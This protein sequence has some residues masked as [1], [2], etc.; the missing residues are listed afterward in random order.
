[1]SG[2]LWVNMTTPGVVCCSVLLDERDERAGVKLKDAD[3]I[4]IPLQII[5]GEKKIGE[6]NLELKT[7]KTGKIITVKKEDALDQFLNFTRE[8]KV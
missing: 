6:G 3:L 1:M 8:F 7:R 4:G 2:V 5:I